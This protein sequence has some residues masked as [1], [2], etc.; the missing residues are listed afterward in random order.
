MI[1]IY[2]ISTFKLTE[3]DKDYLRCFVKTG[4]KNSKA[5][6][7]AYILLSLDK[8]KPQE[9]IMDYFEV[10]RS[11]IW[12]IKSNYQK[13]GLGF[14]LHNAFRSG[15]P[16]KYNSFDE[17]KLIQ[18]ASSIPPYG[19][20]RWTLQLLEDIMKKSYSTKTLNRETIRL[21]LK[22]KNISLRK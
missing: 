22:R 2:M 6:E 19:K 15:K 7:H 18:L 11:T 20:V 17:D 21:I 3:K 9:D 5:I 8:K 10:G 13:H 4:K 12:R 1:Q 16:K 14:A